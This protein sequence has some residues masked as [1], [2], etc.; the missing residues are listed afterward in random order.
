[1]DSKINILIVDDEYDKVQK[2]GAITNELEHVSY[3]RVLDY[4]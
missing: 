1:M 3:D 2:I 4:P